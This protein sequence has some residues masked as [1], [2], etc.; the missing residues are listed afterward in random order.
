[1]DWIF[2]KYGAGGYFYVPAQF[3]AR[4]PGRKLRLAN[5]EEQA[6]AA[7]AFASSFPRPRHISHLR[8]DAAKYRA[9]KAVEPPQPEPQDEGE[10]ETPEEAAPEVEKVEVPTPRPPKARRRRKK[11]EA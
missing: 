4:Y 9:T 11:V 6:L 10:E 8:A 3:V 7:D 2:Q 5:E 1:M